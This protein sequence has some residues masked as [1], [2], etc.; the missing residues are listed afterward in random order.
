[1]PPLLGMFCCTYFCEYG[2]TVFRANGLTALAAQRNAALRGADVLGGRHQIQNALEDVCLLLSNT[3]LSELRLRGTRP[4]SLPIDI[5][6]DVDIPWCV[7]VL[8]P[9]APTTSLSTRSVSSS[10]QDLD[11]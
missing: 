8:P 7:R 5:L 4:A 11:T 1:M 6:Y 3:F 9:L 2:W 10:P